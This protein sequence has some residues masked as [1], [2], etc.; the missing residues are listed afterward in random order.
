VGFGENLI[1]KMLDLLVGTVG[2][3]FSYKISKL[4]D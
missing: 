3:D 4:H 2:F 1:S